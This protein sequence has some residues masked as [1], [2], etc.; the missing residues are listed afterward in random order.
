MNQFQQQIPGVA[1]QNVP[2]AVPNQGIIQQ[3][4]QIQQP[5]INTTSQTISP[6]MQQQIIPGQGVPVSNNIQPCPYTCVGTSS[7]NAISI[8]GHII[9]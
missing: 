7:P 1:Q 5:M 8:A 2:A 3:N 9:V 4:I 6:P